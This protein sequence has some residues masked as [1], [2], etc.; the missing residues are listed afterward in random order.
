ML[1]D[2]N[3]YDVRRR[4]ETQAEQIRPPWQVG[5]RLPIGHHTFFPDY[6]WGPAQDKLL[7]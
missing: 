6:A 5:L 1:L 7:P 2:D 4:Q 3:L